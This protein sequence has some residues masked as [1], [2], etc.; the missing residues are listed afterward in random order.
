MAKYP[1]AQRKAQ[2]ELHRVCPDRMPQFEDCDQLPYVNA[3]IKET[4]RWIPIA[5]IGFPHAVSQ[6]IICGGY[7]IP[8]GAV[9]IPNVWGFLHDPS[10]FRDPM[11]FIPERF[12]DTKDWPAE[13]DLTHT[14]FGWGRRACPGRKVADSALFLTT[15]Q[16]LRVFEV[17]KALDDTSHEI[18]PLIEVKAGTVVHPEPFPVRIVLQSDEHGKLLDSHLKQFKWDDSDAEKL[19]AIPE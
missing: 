19:K 9:I 8:E 14:V 17:K 12:F 2:E 13:P 6:D 16:F 3:L 5:P 7:R 1:D 10:T 4:I 15:A 18:E 11:E